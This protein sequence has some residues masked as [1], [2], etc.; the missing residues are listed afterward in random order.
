LRRRWYVIVGLVLIGGLLFYRQQVAV[1]NAQQKKYTVQRT[2]LKDTLSFS[3]AVDA[4]EKT[5][6]QFQTGGLLS[7]IGVKE[8]DRVNQY[9]TI[10]SLD[11]RQLQKTMQKFLNTYVKQRMIFDRQQ[12]SIDPAIIGSLSTDT[13]NSLITAARESQYDLNNAVLDVEIQDL[14]V[15][16]A[17][18]SSPIKGVVTKLNYPV[19]GVNVALGQTIAEIVNPQT[20]YFS[21]LPDQTDVVKL[22]E[23]MEGEVVLDAYPDEKI[24]AIVQT[25][26]F[27]P[28]TDETGTV[29]QVKMTLGGGDDW[30]LRYRLGMTGDAN[31]V[32]REIPNVLAIPSN[33][34]KSE[35][36]KKYVLKDQNGK[37]V[38]TFIQT[39][40]TIESQTEVASGLKEGDVVYD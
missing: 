7:W 10:A 17:N 36:G 40:E 27:S 25:I 9:Q 28:K 35:N 3:G 15:K 24:P 16:L 22:K 33:F 23:G 2:T 11:Q 38:K 32:L 39:G 4:D 19:A 12:R 20:I 18:I 6:L 34:I 30:T 14:T 37:Q 5:T 26:A 13:Q 8:G 1:K 21:A 29:Y 31:F